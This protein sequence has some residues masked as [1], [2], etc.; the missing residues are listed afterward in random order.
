MTHARVDATAIR[1]KTADDHVVEA[2]KCGEDAHEGDEP[3]RGITGDGEGE[4]DDV[5]FARTP[6]AV[7]NRGGTRR[8]DVARTL[9]ARWDH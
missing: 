1:V 9:N 2:D 3:E 6:V 8:V 7:K 4:A 5:G